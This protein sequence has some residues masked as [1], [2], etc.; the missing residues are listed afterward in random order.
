MDETF[1]FQPDRRRGVIFH[2]AA[3]V[4]LG[5][6][7]L[8]GFWFAGQAV[9]P[10]FLLYLLPALA[11]LAFGPVLVYRLISLNRATY[12]VEREG[13]LLR[14]G[15]RV[16]QI[17]INQVLWVRPAS[18]VTP[19][20]PLPPVRWPGAVRGYRHNASLGEIEFLSSQTRDLVLIATPGKAYAISPA[21]PAGFLLAFDRCTEMGSLA[22]LEKRSLYPTVLFERVWRARP[23]RPRSR[24]AA[25]TSPP[26]PG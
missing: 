14:W 21:D 12:L 24:S 9:G 8:T 4:F 20:L 18:E 25:R 22:P 10:T 23:A 3:L 19:G 5:L 1:V 15:L 26:M 11:A 6:V 7:G 13:I 16:E 17:P 2:L